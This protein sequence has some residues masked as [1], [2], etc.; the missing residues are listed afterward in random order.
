[1][2]IKNSPFNYKKIDTYVSRSAQP[3]RKNFEWLKNEGVTD[4]INL[5]TMHTPK[6][7]F[8]EEEYVK[9]QGMKYHNIPSVSRHPNEENVLKFLKIIEEVKKRGGKVHIHCKQGADRTGMYSYIYERLSKTGRTPFEIYRDMVEHGW[10]FSLYP[11][12]C[13]W[14]EEFVQKFKSLFTHTI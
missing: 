3:D 11:H 10:H 5:R 13:I 12:I 2:E 4:I 7:D 14:A 9:K 6:I 1:M 8:N